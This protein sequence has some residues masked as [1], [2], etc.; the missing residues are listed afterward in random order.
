VKPYG[1]KPREMGD[2]DCAGNREYGRKASVG[3][4]P[5]PGGKARSLQTPKHKS[6]ARRRLKRRAR[7]EGKKATR[8]TP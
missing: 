2:S 8:E 3:N 4:F 6:E 7:A 1:I 5:G